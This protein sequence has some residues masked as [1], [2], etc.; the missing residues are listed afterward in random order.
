MREGVTAYAASLLEENIQR[1]KEIPG[2]LPIDLDKRLTMG[3]KSFFLGGTGQL[4]YHPTCCSKYNNSRL[5]QAEK[6]QL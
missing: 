2:T 5:E 6:E 3:V 1:F 4:L